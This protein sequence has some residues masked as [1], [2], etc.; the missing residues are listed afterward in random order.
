MTEQSENPVGARVDP[1]EPFSIAIEPQRDVVRI[2]PRSELD[3]AIAGQFQREIGLLVDAG[4]TRIV[5]GLPRRRVPG[6][7]C[8]ARPHRRPRP[9]PAGQLGARHHPSATRSAPRLRNHRRDRSPP[10]HHRQ[11]NR[12]HRL[13]SLGWPVASVLQTHRVSCRTSLAAHRVLQRGGREVIAEV[14]HGVKDDGC[15]ALGEFLL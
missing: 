2:G 13:L 10:V 11:G 9:S 7:H 1:P 5:I 15:S 6:L 12:S 3:L 4:F 8:T 14:L